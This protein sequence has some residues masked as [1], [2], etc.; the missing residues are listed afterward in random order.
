MK[1]LNKLIQG[2]F[3]KFVS[4]RDA[5]RRSNLRVKRLLRPYGLAMTAI[6][7][8]LISPTLSFTEDN[9]P[10]NIKGYYKN[11]FTTTRSFDTK[12]GIYADIHRL[13]IELDKQISPGWQAY[14]TLDN[15]AIIN[16]FA[17]TSDFD[18]IRSRTQDATVAVDLDK[19]S[20]DNDHLYL[21]HAIHRAFL[22]YYNPQFQ[23]VLGKQGVDW[24]ILRFYSPLDVFNPVGALDLERDERIGI[25]AVNL[26]F[27]PQSLAGINL[28]AAPGEDAENSRYGVKFY[29][30]LGTYDF[31]IIAATIRKDIIG[32]FAFDGYLKK[33]GLRG[34]ITY[35]QLDSNRAFARVGVG[36]DYSFSDKFYVLFEQFYNG[37]HDDNSATALASSYRT[38]AQLLS[39]QKHLSNLW[40]RYK[41]TPLIELNNYLIYDWDGQSVVVNPEIKYNIFKNLDLS[42]GAQLYW[43]DETSEFG[44]FN[45]LFYIQ[46]KWYF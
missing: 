15:E 38:S 32:G 4:L 28:V 43:G 12:E 19:T 11:L 37:G 10:L 29:K 14:L 20:V 13:R 7:F 16:D 46:L 33:A 3:L 24:G 31:S 30:T 44:L 27:S 35:N 2:L 1:N 6:F 39:L 40:L 34:E 21:K 26:N 5:K 8:I 17:N 45:H 42:F 18:F 36:L 9:N 23:A 25:D 22:K 41:L